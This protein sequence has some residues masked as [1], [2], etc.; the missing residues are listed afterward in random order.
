M[1]QEILLQPEFEAHG[2]REPHQRGC[3]RDLS[4]QCREGEGGCQ[5]EAL[6]LA[7]FNH[8]GRLLK[9]SLVHPNRQIYTKD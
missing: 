7:A 9:I 6:G 4:G 8:H 1:T 3:G 5:L 2:F